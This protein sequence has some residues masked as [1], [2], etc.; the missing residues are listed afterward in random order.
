MLGSI[1]IVVLSIYLSI[2]NWWCSIN[3]FDWLLIWILLRNG[4][5]SSFL[6]V[7]KKRKNLHKKLL[8]SPKHKI[9]RVSEFISASVL[10]STG[11]QPLAQVCAIIS[12]DIAHSSGPL[13]S[14]HNEA[15]AGKQ[16]ALAAKLFSASSRSDNKTLVNFLCPIYALCELSVSNINKPL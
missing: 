9:R 7:R 13:P 10:L 3:A 14:S 12:I 16:A 8:R 6:M 4:Y 2:E 1:T 11:H 15:R 5:F